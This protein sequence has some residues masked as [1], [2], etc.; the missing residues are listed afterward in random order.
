MKVVEPINK[1]A[2]LKV[3]EAG[4][5]LSPFT[6]ILW[7]GGAHPSEM[8]LLLGELPNDTLLSALRWWSPSTSWQSAK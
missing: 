1:L 5:L 8:Q 6:Y 7:G 2:E 4:L 3:S